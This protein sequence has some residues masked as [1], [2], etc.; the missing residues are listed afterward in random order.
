LNLDFKV[1]IKMNVQSEQETSDLMKSIIPFLQK[2]SI[3]L[4][5]GDLGAGKTTSIRYL[6]EHYGLKHVQSPTYSI[7]QRYSASDISI[8]HFD[9]YRLQSDDE[10]VSTGFWDLLQSQNSLMIIEWFERIPAT[11]WLEFEKQ[12]RSVFGLKIE[13]Q[14]EFEERIFQF[15]ELQKD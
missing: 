7:H 4:L 3:L 14:S 15:F 1:R 11:D 13:L 9:L 8:D 10:L 12:R 5:S 6:C 2:N